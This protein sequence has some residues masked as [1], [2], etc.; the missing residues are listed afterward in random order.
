MALTDV[1]TGLAN[2]AVSVG[3]DGLLSEDDDDILTAGDGDILIFVISEP[4]TVP[5]QN[6]TDRPMTRVRNSQFRY[7]L[8]LSQTPSTSE[9]RTLG[10]GMTIRYDIEDVYIYRSVNEGSGFEGAMAGLLAYMTA[11]DAVIF[12]AK[13]TTA[14]RILT[15]RMIPSVITYPT[16]SA[17]QYFGVRCELAIEEYA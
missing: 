17:T 1:L 11:Y 13:P 16:G 14:S 5:V 12:D 6:A 2:I 9:K 10:S 15:V 7:L 3:V 8:P 4:A